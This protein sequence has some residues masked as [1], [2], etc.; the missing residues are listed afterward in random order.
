MAIPIGSIITE[1]AVLEIH[2]D[3][4]VV[5][6][7]NPKIIFVTFVPIKLIMFRAI[8]LCKFHRSIV[9]A[10]TKP[11]KYKNTYLCPNAAVVSA[12]PKAPV[13]G[14]RMIGNKAVTSIGIASVIH[15][16]AIHKVT[17]NTALA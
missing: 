2:I 5:A 6:N 4:A 15:Q 17:A 16:I 7:M 11:P 13:K 3:I 9:I 1:V 12:K 10:I 8:R 14:N